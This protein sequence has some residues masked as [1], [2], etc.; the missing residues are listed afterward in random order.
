MLL[1]LILLFVMKTSSS[2][3]VPDRLPP[4]S[5]HCWQDAEWETQRDLC[6]QAVEPMLQALQGQGPVRKVAHRAGQPFKLMSNVE[7]LDKAT[8]NKWTPTAI[9]LVLALAEIIRAQGLNMED[10]VYLSRQPRQTVASAVKAD[11]EP[12]LR[13]WDGVARGFGL[14][15]V[16]LAFLGHFCLKGE[17][18]LKER[19]Q[20]QIGSAGFRYEM[21][22]LIDLYFHQPED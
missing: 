12:K 9:G 6:R 22:Y 4:V 1:L 21:R 15:G 5:E 10:V 8:E 18:L 20:K 7:L 11:K 3:D 19:I 17:L 13:F 2:D 14:D 16:E